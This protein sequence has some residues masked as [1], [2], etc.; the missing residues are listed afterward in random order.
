MEFGNIGATDIEVLKP[1]SFETLERQTM[2]IGYLRATN[3]GVWKSLSDK[4][5][6]IRV[7][8][9]LAETMTRWW[10]DLKSGARCSGA[11]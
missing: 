5:A 4:Q 2:K 11:N 9:V 8:K 3:M 1:G 6:N 7:W 10:E